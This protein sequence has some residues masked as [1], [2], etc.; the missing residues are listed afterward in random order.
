MNVLREISRTISLPLHLHCGKTYFKPISIGISLTGRCNSRCTMCDF[1]KENKAELDFVKL[2][3]ILEKINNFGVS[4]INYSAHGEIFVHREIRKILAHTHKRGFIQ[5]LNTNALALSN[6]NLAKFVADKAQPLLISIGLDSMR[7][8]VYEKIR[9]IPSGQYKVLQGIQ[10]LQARGIKNITIGSVILDYNLDDLIQLVEFAEKMQLSALRFT[11]YQRYFQAGEA[12]ET[13]KRISAPSFQPQLQ[14]T[15]NALVKLKP[16]HPIIRNSAAYL[17]CVSEFYRQK[18]YFPF[19]CIVG[20]LRMDI[21]ELGDVTL[22]PF[23]GKSIGN[24]F[25]NELADIWFSEQAE[26]I[27][28]QMVQGEC[29]SCLLSCYTE[30]NIRFTPKYALRSNWDAFKRFLKLVKYDVVRRA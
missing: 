17:A 21:D 18:Y 25:D 30:E 1:W 15:M 14:E 7:E 11:A 3:I 8:D 6:T 5:T 19:K 26:N 24:V 28:K 9:G 23:I 27:R 2:E 13:W 16:A 20:Y 22:C 29:P 12:D 10:N 4:V